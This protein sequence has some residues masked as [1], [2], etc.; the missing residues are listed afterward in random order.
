MAS[1]YEENVFGKI[2]SPV[3]DLLEHSQ[4]DIK[5]DGET[6]NLSLQPFTINLLFGIITQIGSIS[7]LITEIK[8]SIVAK[9]LKLVNASKAMYS[10]AFKRYDA[11]IYRGIFY[12]LLSTLNFLGIPEI[13]HLGRILLV[14]GSV[15]PAIANMEWARYKKNA[16]AIKMQM[17]F[18]LN[19]MIPVA[20]LCTEGNYS[21]KKFLIEIIEESVTYICDRGYISFKMFKQIC[22]KSAF[23]IIRGKSNMQYIVKEQ[24]DVIM[25]N[26]FLKFFSD[27][28]DKKVFFI[29]D[30]DAL[31]YRIV[32]FTAMGESYALITNRLDLTTYEVI[33][34]YAY[35]WQVELC[36]RFLKRTLCGI[37]LWSHD[38]NGVQVQFYVYMIAYLLLLSFKQEC[39][40]LNDTH[41]AEK[42]DIKIEND[43]DQSDKINISNANT[44]RPYVCGLV[45]LLGRK[46]KKYW[47]I[48][49][50]WLTAL[51]NQ[52]LKIF[53]AQV[54]SGISGYD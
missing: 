31:I 15:F 13:N 37:H 47:K 53:S 27:L 39:E 48:G 42:V 10:D 52:L 6:Y 4:N 46:L 45:S 40:L 12:Q 32:K 26:E 17:S 24:L 23:F 9:K 22:D 8:T 20:F 29:N 51:K 19:R 43:E 25:P 28:S 18:E 41:K 5:G 38:E 21:E 14:D 11:K 3:L 30:D 36:F 2:L 7:L 49:I 1:Q 35:R 16:N 50:H 54:V 34:L 33:M 44:Q